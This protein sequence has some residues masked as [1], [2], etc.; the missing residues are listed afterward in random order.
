[1]RELSHEDAEGRLWR[2]RIPDHAP[3]S[4]ATMGVIVGPPPMDEL[5]LPEEIAIRLHNQL[6]HRG[7][8]TLKDV[9]RRKGDVVGALH[10]TL[11]V[12]VQRIV[13]IYKNHREG[14]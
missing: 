1:M 6:Y 5:G 8:F 13:D 2:V 9:E 4:D 11:K 7:L 3:D 10:A 14:G 12:D